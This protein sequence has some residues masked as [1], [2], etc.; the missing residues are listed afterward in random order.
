LQVPRT[1][2]PGASV[3]W[4]AAL[5]AVNLEQT[6]L[7]VA[8]PAE[9]PGNW[10][11]APSITYDPVRARWLLYWRLRTKDQ[12]GLACSIAESEDGLY[13]SP[14]WSAKQSE[15]DSPSLEKASLVYCPDELFR[16]Y[17]SYEVKG[18]G[19]QV[20]VMEAESP[21][22]FE[23]STRK[24]VLTPAQLDC[25]HVKDP[26]VMIVGG[27]YWMYVDYGTGFESTG[28]AISNDGVNFEWRGQVMPLGEGWDSYTARATCVCRL[29]GLWV[30]FYDGCAS[31]EESRE[32]KAGLAVSFDLQRWFRLSSQAP[33]YTSPYGSGS[34]RYLE[35]IPV[36][37]ETYWLYFEA[38]RPDGA[39][40]LRRAV[41]RA[42]FDN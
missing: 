21:E 7:V 25:N 27:Q 20:D 28:L 41:V 26:F 16:L 42:S 13:F 15:F 14:I 2:I 34:L 36:E 3:K 22:D 4:Y 40:E 17:I 24:T 23:P 38:A 5:P 30:M 18:K 9:G 32:E 35:C 11:G 37:R 33:R 29:Q 10:A 12:R 1:S 19:W 39:H 6:E 8:A 31:L